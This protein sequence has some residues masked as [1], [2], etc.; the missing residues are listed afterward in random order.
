MTYEEM[1]RRCREI[2]TIN[3]EIDDL[4]KFYDIIKSDAYT[5]VMLL[6]GM[7]K[8]SVRSRIDSAT[9]N[10]SAVIDYLQG[11]IPMRIEYLKG[12]RT[13]IERTEV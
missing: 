6:V 10:M 13:V 12:T 1:K 7:P 8:E 9:C 2:E 4:Q 5:D 11:Y 3:R